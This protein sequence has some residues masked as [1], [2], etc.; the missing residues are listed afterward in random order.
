LLWIDLLIS[1]LTTRVSAYQDVCDCFELLQ[2]LDKLST[3]EL[4][5]AANN[6]VEIY[7][8]DIESSLG[9]EFTQF[10]PLSRLF[11]EDKKDEMSTEQ[12]MFTMMAKKKLKS[13]FPNIDIMLRIYPC[14]LVSNCSGEVIFKTED[15]KESS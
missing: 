14:M 4:R 11:H 10:T 8:S 13:T 3:E 12:W 9:D 5:T 6:Q 7:S 15:Y 2:Q 1:A